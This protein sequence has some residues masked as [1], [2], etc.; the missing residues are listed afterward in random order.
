VSLTILRDHDRPTHAEKLERWLGKEEVTRLSVMMREWYGPPIHLLDTPGSV[1]VAA[2]GDFVGQIGRG[3][4][5]VGLDYA[6]DR[7]RRH[8]QLRM[9]AGFASISDA[10]SR[11]S[12]GFRQGIPF[13]KIGPTG[14]GGVTSSLWRVGPQPAVGAAPANPAGGTA[15]DRTSVGALA[16]RNAAAGT[17]RLTGADVSTN[18]LGNTLLLYDLIFGVNKT[19]NSTSQ[20]SVT[21]V[22]TR[23]QSSTPSAEDYAGGN[24]LFVQVGGTALPATGHNWTVCTYRN[25]AGT[26]AQ[27][28]PSLAGVASAIVDRLDHPNASLQWFAPLASG[29]SGVMDLAAIQCSALVA[30]GVVWFMIGHP[31]GFMSFPVQNCILPFD[32]LTNRDQA[33]RIFD[34]A[35]LALLEPLK[36]SS[37][38]ASY[39]GMVYATDTAA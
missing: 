7:Y 11:A 18:V 23:Y 1:R 39:T 19:M 20:E 6:I 24:F 33:P 29:D 35:C 13:N 21:G 31:I 5:S 10:L 32:W 27:T 36:P 25:Q 22:P 37:S 15:Y 34:N 8:Q 16:W 26:D 14:V 12:Q 38:A 28:L 3:K 2:G 4:F 9:M 30:T 17:S